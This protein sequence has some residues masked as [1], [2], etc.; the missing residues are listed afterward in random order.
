MRRIGIP[1][2]NWPEADRHLWTVLFRKGHPLD[3][4]GRLAHFRAT[5][6]EKLRNSYSYW[7][8]WVSSTAPAQLVVAPLERVS[9]G[10]LEAW[11]RSMHH[12]APNTIGTRLQA[13]GQILR[14]MDPNRPTRAE[15]SVIRHAKQH[16]E[17]VG[18]QRK[19]GRVVDSAILLLSLIHI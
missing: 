2:S 6:E 10:G 16:A 9:A 11:R 18:S 17:F 8:A 3:D 13:M 7:L 14:G 19:Q 12:L 4:S 5:S 15:K 1:F